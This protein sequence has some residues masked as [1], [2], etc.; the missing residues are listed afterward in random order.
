MKTEKVSELT[1]NRLS[2][3]LRCLNELSVFN[4]KTISSQAMADQ[5]NLNSAQIRKDLAYFGEFGVRGVGYYVEDLRR[6]LMKILGLTEKRRVAIVGLGNLGMA[7]A[8][9][10]GFGDNNFEI[11][12]LFDD[13]PEKIGKTTRGGLEIHDAR[14]IGETIKREFIEIV[15]IAVPA[16][17]AE[18]V[19]E[20]VTDAGVHAVLN[21]APVHLNPRPGIKVKNVDLTISLESLSYFLANPSE[22]AVNVHYREFL[23]QDSNPHGANG[24]GS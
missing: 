13:D 9:Y 24:T 12:A 3:Y 21:F 20:E 8:N 17:A 6:H 1:T 14:K 5:F 4:V 15:I 2:I 7:L 18:R 10:H 19:L 22:E 23:R 11:A 16:T